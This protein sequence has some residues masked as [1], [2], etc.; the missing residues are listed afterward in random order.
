[1][2]TLNKQGLLQWIERNKEQLDWD[3]NPFGCSDW[4]RLFAEQICK[5]DWRYLVDGFTLCYSTPERPKDALALRNYYTCLFTISSSGRMPEMDTMDLA[6]VTEE[7]AEGF[8]RAVPRQWYARKYFASANHYLP[9]SKLSFD[10]YFETRPS[11]VRN[12][13]KRKAKKFLAAGGVLEMFDSEKD[14]ERG[15]AAYQQIYAHSWK[16]PEP[17]AEFVPDWIRICARKGWLRLAVAWMD[18]TPI[19]AQFWFTRNR[20]A[21]VYKLAYDEAHKHWSAGTLLTVELMRRSLDVDK[22]NEVD[23]LSGDDAYKRMWMTH[24]RE[25]VGIKCCNLL[26]VRGLIA[27]V[28]EMVGALKHSLKPSAPPAPPHDTGDTARQPQSA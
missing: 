15:I 6:P 3:H 21:Y 28:R 24:R 19:A 13:W 18:G 20:V 17:Y 4:L 5:D 8:C 10:Q 25:R 9:C 1:M 16:D 14:L 7:Q 22:V 26:T 23:Y 2:E 27:A 12:T 11:E